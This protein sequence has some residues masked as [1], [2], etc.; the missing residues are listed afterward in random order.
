MPAFSRG[1]T[2][3]AP[4][5]VIDAV[6]VSPMIKPM[7]ARSNYL[8]GK[9]MSK[10]T[11]GIKALAVLALSGVLTSQAMADTSRCDVTPASRT[12]AGSGGTFRVGA[13]GLVRLTISSNAATP[14]QRQGDAR[15]LT[16]SNV[17]VGRVSL[18]GFPSQSG[19]VSLAPGLTVKLQGITTT[20]GASF[21]V[22]ATKL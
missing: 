9:K 1:T 2:R 16:R 18:R 11:L 7:V 15:L 19:I 4:A 5:H 12:C 13:S 22:S 21:H 8:K 14:A 10:S 6:L 3:Q 17:I 20:P